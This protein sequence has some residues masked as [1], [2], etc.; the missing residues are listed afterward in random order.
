MLIVVLDFSTESGCLAFVV[1]IYA[2][3]GVVVG[4]YGKQ[5][6]LSYQDS[7]GDSESAVNAYG[8]LM[9]WKMNVSLGGVLSGET[10]S[11][12]AAAREDNVLV[13][14]PSG[15]ADKCIDGNDKAFRVCFYSLFK[16]GRI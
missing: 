15:S 7:Q 11:I 2:I 14:T 6:E 1:E 9:D 16:R 13:I 8:K 10:A 4:I 5:I 3:D 12:A